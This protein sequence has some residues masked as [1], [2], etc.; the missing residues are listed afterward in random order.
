M[1]GLLQ[2]NLQRDNYADFLKYILIWTVVLG[3]FINMYQCTVGLVGGLYNC[4]YTFHMPL[5][6]FV[7]GYFSKHLNNYRR[8]N[9]DTLLYPFIVFQLLNVIYTI[10]FPIEPLNGNVLYP[11]HQNWYLLALFWWRTFSPYKQF[12]KDY[13]VVVLCIVV[14]LCSGFFPEIGMFLGL[15]KTLYFLPFFILGTYCENLTLLLEKLLRHK[16]AWNV[17]FI[18]LMVTV[19]LMSFNE[20]L[21]VLLN[22]GFKANMGYDGDWT[23]LIIRL[24][25]FLVSIAAC[26]SVLVVTKQLYNILR[27][28]GLKLSGGAQS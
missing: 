16:T 13:I 25:S 4:I 8:K 23:N 19:F 18:L 28:R 5:F 7:S 10:V 20:K 15:Y 9:F 26:C 1:Q 3:H 17:I 2:A 24:L 12:F 22:Y 21:I 27:N 6:V 14:C 11:Y